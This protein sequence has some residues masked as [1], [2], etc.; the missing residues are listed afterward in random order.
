[1]EKIEEFV[2]DRQKSWCIQCGASIGSVETSE[3]HVPSKG[4]LREPRPENL[5]VVDICTSCNNGFSADEEYLFLFLNCVLARTTDPDR[6]DEP[7]VGR[8]LRRHEKLRARIE[9]SRT[10]HQTPDGETRL[11]WKPETDR[12]NRVI[13]KNARG[14]AFYEYGEPMLREPDQVRAAPLESLTAAQRD[15]FENIQGD[16]M[17]AGWP[18]VGSRMMSR[19]MTGQDLR[20]GW[21]IVQDG[22]YRFGVAQSGGI[23]VRSVLFEYLATEVWWDDCP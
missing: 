9:R 20:D 2:D 3:D 14:H 23:L 6:Q 8:A 12:V 10:E 17:L 19:V 21:V 7:K 5:P 11:V 18:E 16:G 15:A 1:M 13:V 4:L 22:V